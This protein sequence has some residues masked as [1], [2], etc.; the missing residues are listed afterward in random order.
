MICYRFEGQHYLRNRHLDDCDGVDCSGC[1]PCPERHCGECRQG[2]HLGYGENTCA[3]CV[4][5][6]RADLAAL[7][8]LAAC[9]PA[10]AVERGVD[11]EAANLDGPV[12]DPEAF[13]HR[14]VSILAG[15]INVPLPEEDEHHPLAVL[16]RWVLMLGEDYGDP[17]DLTLDMSRAVDY[18]DA[19]LGRI[20]HDAGQDF[21]QFKREVRRSRAH[22]EAVLHDGE[23]RDTGAPC[24]T[25]N[26]PLQKTWA[27]DEKH[28][29][30][31]CP[32][33][34][35]TSTHAQY[36]FA[37]QHLHRSEAT[38]LTDQDMELRTGVKAGTV[39]VWARRD[40]V[41]RK[42]EQGRTVYSV[43]DVLKRVQ[44]EAS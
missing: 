29:G 21:G 8:E 38:H 36:Q 6:T 1:Q 35:H 23:Q 26:V 4:G 14:R 37:V 12:A 33:C 19:R 22:L 9:L 10:E 24:M 30:W 34:K 40:E 32:K 15:R 39:R 11:S 44:G 31:R 17:T 43:S 18:L 42:R 2:R 27:A 25:C 28:D 3:E 13:S 7:L 5:H 16:G 20:A 41:E